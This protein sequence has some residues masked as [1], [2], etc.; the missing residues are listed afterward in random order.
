MTKWNE[1]PF[2]KDATPEE[3]ADE[4]DRQYAENQSDEPDKSN[5]YSKENFGK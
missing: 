2:N 4:F 1:I 5:P 3:K